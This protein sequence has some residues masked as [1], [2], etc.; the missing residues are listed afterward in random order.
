[1]SFGAFL[2]EEG[3]EMELSADLNTVI[4]VLDEAVPSFS[5]TGY[6]YQ[7][8]SSKGVLGKGWKL[9]VK[10]RDLATSTQ[11]HPTVGFI[12]L[13]KMED[14]KTSCRV[15]PRNQWGDDEANDFDQDGKVFASFIFHLLNTFQ[16]RGFINLPGQFP[17]S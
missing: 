11:L 15:P 16:G 1:M 12:E 3:V 7:V 9:L 10:S 14:G 2:L 8:D 13:D 17:I 4:G 5:Y 6:G